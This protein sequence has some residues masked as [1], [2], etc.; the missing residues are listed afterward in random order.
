MFSVDSLISVPYYV[1]FLGVGGFFSPSGI[2]SKISVTTMQLVKV[3][4]KHSF[5]ALHT[6]PQ[7]SPQNKEC[8]VCRMPPAIYIAQANNAVAL[9]NAWR[10]MY[11]LKAKTKGL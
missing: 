8:V 4:T 6:G 11:F 2:D 7:F 3:F 9:S 1:G 5:S 10:Y